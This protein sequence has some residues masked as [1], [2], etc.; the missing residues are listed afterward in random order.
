M[1]K[2]ARR[3]EIREVSST[4][5]VCRIAGVAHS[6]QTPSVN[7]L[8]RDTHPT[9]EAVRL[10]LLRDAPPS[11]RF[12]AMRSLTAT[13]V[14]LAK[15]GIRKAHPDLTEREL[16]LL[17]VEVHYGRELADR[18]RAFLDRRGG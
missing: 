17:F 3:A 16:S 10:Q 11:R 8:S 1:A 9:A 5:Y 18:L 14:R 7:T 15:R 4:G 13:V 2:S 6:W 12:A